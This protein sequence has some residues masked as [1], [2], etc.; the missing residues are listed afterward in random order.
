[1]L[2]QEIKRELNNV[3]PDINPQ[4]ALNISHLRQRIQRLH[5]DTELAQR[6][7]FTIESMSRTLYTELASRAHPQEHESVDLYAL[8]RKKFESFFY[9]ERIEW[10]SALREDYFLLLTQTE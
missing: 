3:D 2:L 5:Q 10:E 6:A 4:Q 8:L 9:K 1:M 7:M